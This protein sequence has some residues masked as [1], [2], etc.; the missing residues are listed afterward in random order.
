[1][2]AP[3]FVLHGSK[4]GCGRSA[5][6]VI[7]ATGLAALGW[8]PLHIQVTLDGVPPVIAGAESVPF[9]T[10]WVP[11][12]DVATYR[13]IMNAIVQHSDCR[14]IVVD[15][16]RVPIWELVL[17]DPA[18]VIFPVRREAYEIETALIDYRDFDR[19]LRSKGFAP[20][21]WTPPDKRHR[22]KFLMPVSWP[23][24]M[25]DDHV[26]AKIAQH[27]P[28][29]GTPLSFLMPGIPELPEDDLHDLIN[30]NRFKCSQTI[31]KAAVEIAQ[32]AI[33]SRD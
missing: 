4:G 25:S 5:S 2:S 33:N 12:E 8:K 32:A 26:A 9:R 19:Y 16:T 7:L 31:R 17:N 24:N 15:M 20:H 27:D 22:P 6:A 30:T 13:P 23:K 29:P 18:V 3:V 28:E 10:A 21:P 14:A 11:D 1:M